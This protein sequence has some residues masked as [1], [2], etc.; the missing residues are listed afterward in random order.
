MKSWK[1]LQAGLE[2]HRVPPYVGVQD[3]PAA[4][5]YAYL[6]RLVA[7][8]AVELYCRYIPHYYLGLCVK[9]HKI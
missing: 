6:Q 2:G 1:H 4:N 5:P 7:V 8:L 9:A 3:D